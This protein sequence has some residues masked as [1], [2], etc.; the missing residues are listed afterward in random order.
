MHQRQRLVLKLDLANF[1]PSIH[2][3]RVQGLFMAHPFKY[4]E[5]VAT[6]LAHVCCHE[7]ELP[8]G[9]PT[10][11][12]VS[13]YICRR[14]DQ[15]LGDLANEERCFFS[16]YADDLTFSTDRSTFPSA[17]VGFTSDGSL[18]LEPKLRGLIE[19]N[20]FALNETKIRFMRRTQRQRVTGLVINKKPNVSSDYV[21]SLRNVLYI[22]RAHGEE[23][24]IT[25][26]TKHGRP[27]HRPPGKPAPSL[28]VVIRGRVQYVGSVRGWNSSTYRSLS[29][30]LQE[31]D[32]TFRPTVVRS[33]TTR[34]TVKVYVEGPSDVV[35][36]SAAQDYF[37][38]RGQFENLRLEFP[39]DAVAKSDA[40][41]WQKC[42]QLAFSADTEMSACVFDGDNE[43]ILKQALED[44][45]GYRV[46]SRRVVSVR[47]ASPPWRDL[48]EPLCI[49]MLHEP[50]FLAEPAA[51]DRRIYLVEEFDKAGL[52]RDGR[53]RRG[54]QKSGALVQVDVRDGLTDESVGLSKLAFAEHAATK[55]GL[56]WEG[57]K[58][59]F[60]RLEEAIAKI[61]G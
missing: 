61:V 19:S 4:P 41:L 54:A 50:A 13:N 27:P 56:S 2:F 5:E 12:V 18:V 34:T 22:W 9:A 29:G 43:Q 49:E 58:P 11:P 6:L 44:P 30:A 8:Q 37:H 45:P 57:F 39:E 17:W 23:A 26:F 40:A 51:G 24:A 55:D 14:L 53:V 1:F 35:H 46:C 25:S 32:P 42:K 7:N 21:R 36:L 47:I 38:G 59:T 10:S 16:R 3:G 52:H 31:C 20:G 28:A 48:D 60:E 33:L 15:E